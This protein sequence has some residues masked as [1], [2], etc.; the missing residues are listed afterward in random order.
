MGLFALDKLLEPAALAE[1]LRSSRDVLLVHVASAPAYAAGHIERAIHV[2]PGEL[3]SG[4]RPA[5]GQ[6]PDLARIRQLFSRIG[7]RPHA[8]IVAYDDEGGGW[9]GRFI[10]T[11]DVIGHRDWA[12]LDGGI[13][14]WAAAGLPVSQTNL[15]PQPT[16]VD[17]AIDRAPIADAADILERLGDPDLV[18]WDCRGADEYAGVRATAA[19]NGHIP[20]AVHLDWL[21]LMDPSRQ[22]RLRRD[23]AQLL[24]SRGITPD[25]DVIAHCQ[26]HHRSGLAYLVARLLEYPSIRGYHGSWSE[27]GNREDTPIETG[28]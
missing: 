11:L 24:A 5:T 7:Y 28:R 17:I 9:A 26:T 14:A 21:D 3:V 23:I 16:N 2:A 27:W 6:L 19:R 18:V 20:G 15:E 25:K 13:H 8:T 1:L 12:Y 22:L 10:W 4:V